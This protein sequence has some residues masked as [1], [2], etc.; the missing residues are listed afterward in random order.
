LESSYREFT[1]H[2]VQGD[3]ESENWAFKAPF[4]NLVERVTSTLSLHLPKTNS[5]ISSVTSATQGRKPN[6]ADSEV[7][8]PPSMFKMKRS[9]SYDATYLK[10]QLSKAGAS[11][12][13]GKHTALR[14]AKFYEPFH[15]E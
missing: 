6:V 15:S 4:N 11:G 5:S 8:E 10:S 12:D 9:F 3:L 2:I 1:T 14:A 7:Y 13:A